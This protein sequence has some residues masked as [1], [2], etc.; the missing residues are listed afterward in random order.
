MS[1]SQLSTSGYGH[2]PR[3]INSQRTTPYDHWKKNQA[4]TCNITLKKMLKMGVEL[5]DAYYKDSNGIGLYFT[6][7]LFRF[8]FNEL[9]RKLPNR[10]A[11]N[12]EELWILDVELKFQ[13]F[14][15]ASAFL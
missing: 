12:A 14:N 3:V 11:P 10:F 1:T 8:L 15:H 13:G 5:K 2:T 7:S 9:T 6:D 4:K